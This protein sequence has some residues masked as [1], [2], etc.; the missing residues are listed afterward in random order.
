MMSLYTTNQHRTAVAYF[1]SF[2]L[3]TCIFLGII[4]LDTKAN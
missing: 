2:I 1:H 4:Y 3:S